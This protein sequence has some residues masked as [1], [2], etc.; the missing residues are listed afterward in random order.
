MVNIS[1]NIELPDS[2]P[3]WLPPPAP[4]R[5]QIPRDINLN[6]SLDPIEST[7]SPDDALPEVT[8]TNKTPTIDRDSPRLPD[9]TTLAQSN[10]NAMH[11]PKPTPARLAS[12]VENPYLKTD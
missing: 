4:Q 5:D 3:T 7:D 6:A 10:S 12:A 1:A 2:L 9:A 11:S 8:R